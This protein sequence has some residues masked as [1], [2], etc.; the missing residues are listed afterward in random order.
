MAQKKE[1][2]WQME[3]GQEDNLSAKVNHRRST[4]FLNCL[5]KSANQKTNFILPVLCCEWYTVDSGLTM[6][7]LR[8]SCYTIAMAWHQVT[9]LKSAPGTYET[10]CF[11]SFEKKKRY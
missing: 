11:Q 5:V 4:L 8:V 3:V 2:V 10:A 7:F 1:H 6:K 9:N